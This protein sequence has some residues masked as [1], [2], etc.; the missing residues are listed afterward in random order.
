VP[1]WD[2]HM[3]MNEGEA[4]ERQQRSYAD[5]KLNEPEGATVRRTDTVS[6]E[7]VTGTLV[8]CGMAAC[9]A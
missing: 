9:N 2:H 6:G 4:R 5:R 3:S 1:G 8:T 7:F